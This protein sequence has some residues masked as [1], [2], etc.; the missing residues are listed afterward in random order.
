MTTMV[1][2]RWSASR[3]ALVA[4]VALVAAPT[5]RGDKLPRMKET[6]PATLDLARARPFGAGREMTLTFPKGEPRTGRDF[7]VIACVKAASG[8]QGGPGSAK[9]VTLTAVMPEH[10]HG[11]L[12]VPVREESRR[13]AGCALWKGL[14]FHMPGWW[15]VRLQDQA[16]GARAEFHFDLPPG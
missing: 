4:L 10:A 5:A 13:D 3:A 7:D 15:R 14:R 6:R 12:V 9:G 1:S 11:M 8:G 16:S 2:T